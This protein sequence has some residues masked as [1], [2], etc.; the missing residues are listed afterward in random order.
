MCVF[1]ESFQQPI[2]GFRCNIP[3]G[4]SL[5]YINLRFAGHAEAWQKLTEQVDGVG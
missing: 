2:L 5:V 1:V 3:S 4:F